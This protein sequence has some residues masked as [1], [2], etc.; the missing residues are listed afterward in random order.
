METIKFD[1]NR[2]VK[3]WSSMWWFDVKKGQ[4]K[5]EK[6]KERG[7]GERER[8]RERQTEMEEKALWMDY[9][10]KNAME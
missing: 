10:G 6:E 3:G 1:R 7:I 2:E 5:G 9:E 4:K 8:E